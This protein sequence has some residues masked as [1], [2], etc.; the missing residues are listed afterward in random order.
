MS[1]AKAQVPMHGATEFV[2]LTDLLFFGWRDEPAVVCRAV[3]P[4]DAILIALALNACAWAGVH[5]ESSEMAHGR[6][7]PRVWTRTVA[8][9]VAREQ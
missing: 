3:S 5:R 6:D 9:A 8:S 7:K 4:A 1:V 2:D